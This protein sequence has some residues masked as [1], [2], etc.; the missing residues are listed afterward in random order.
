[1]PLLDGKGLHPSGEPGAYGNLGSSHLAA[2]LKNAFYLLV[3]KIEP[4][5]QRKGKDCEPG[6]QKIQFLL[7]R[8]TSL[9]WH[10]IRVFS[11]ETISYPK[12]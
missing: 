9:E 1:M 5:R 3:L 2:R 11:S 4:E 7:H 10:D 6:N 8:F 12:L